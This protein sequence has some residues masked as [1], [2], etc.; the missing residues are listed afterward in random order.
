MRLS[1]KT[2]DII[3]Y[4]KC[5]LFNLALRGGGAEDRRPPHWMCQCSESPCI[6]STIVIL[7]LRLKE[8]LCHR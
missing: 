5:V 7:T 2:F 8:M 6:R 4:I 3:V 1:R